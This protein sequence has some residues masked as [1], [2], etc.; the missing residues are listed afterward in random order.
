MLWDET[1][2]P[3]LSFKD[4]SA[5]PAGDTGLTEIRAAINNDGGCVLRTA[6]VMT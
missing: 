1:F 3:T 5:A 4:V 2:G 6:K